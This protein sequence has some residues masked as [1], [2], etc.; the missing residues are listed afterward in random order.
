[1]DVEVMAKDQ[2]TARSL[3][4]RL[5]IANVNVELE[6]AGLPRAE[7]LFADGVYQTAPG[8]TVVSTDVVVIIVAI[9]ATGILLPLVVTWLLSSWRQRSASRK[10][11]GGDA[12]I[13]TRNAIAMGLKVSPPRNE[14]DGR[15]HRGMTPINFVSSTMER[16][17]GAKR[18]LQLSTL[19]VREERD[20]SEAGRL[21]EQRLASAVFESKHLS[22]PSEVL[23]APNNDPPA[24]IPPP[25]SPQP[26]ERAEAPAIIPPYTRVETEVSPEIPPKPDKRAEVSPPFGAGVILDRVESDDAV[27]SKLRRL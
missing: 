19:P 7:I 4:E 24:I 17:E 9:A 22:P 23:E 13:V 15:R 1:V 10:L 2:K 26:D 25:I 16:D 21:A 12:E 27:S 20:A 14:I 8:N 3:M 5:T 6:K 18:D 11:Q